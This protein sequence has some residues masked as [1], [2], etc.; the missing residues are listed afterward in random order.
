ML[1]PRQATLAV[2]VALLLFAAVA[3]PRRRGALGAPDDLGAAPQTLHLD[4][5]DREGRHPFATDAS[6]VLVGRSPS[7]A[8]RLTDPTVSRLHARIERRGAG[9]YVEDLGS[10]NGTLLNG[11]P[12]ARETSLASGDRV[13]VGSTEIVFVGLGEWK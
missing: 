4:L 11:T 7:A 12:L 3:A 10:R 6:I 9:V 8:I 2:T 5:Y 13:R 1:D